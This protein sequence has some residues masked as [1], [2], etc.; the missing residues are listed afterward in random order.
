MPTR[1][2][3]RTD[4]DDVQ[5]AA[6][7]SV[8]WAGR[9]WYLATRSLVGS[10]FAADPGLVEEPTITDEISL[11]AGGDVGASFPVAFCLPAVR[12]QDLIDAGYDLEDITLELA[13]VWHRDGQLVHEWAAREVR[14]VGY[15]IE[16]VHDDPEQ[17]AGYIACTLEDSPYRTERPVVPF[18]WEITLDTFNFAP[19]FD[20][21]YPWV[22]GRPAPAGEQG[23]PPAPVVLQVISGAALVNS[24]IMVSV[25]WSV[26]SQVKVHDSEGNSEVASIVYE[27]DGL[28]QTCALVDLS[29]T[30]LDDTLGVT[31]TTAWTEGPA[32]TPYGDSD[33]LSIAAYLLAIG[34]ADI[35]IPAWISSS[36]LLDLEMGGYIDDP[37]SRAWE[38]ARN[39]LSGLPVTMRRARDGWAPVLLDPYLAK[40]VC[41]TTWDEDGPYRRVSSWAGAGAARVGQV[42]VSADVSDLRIGSTPARDAALPHS[43]VRHLDGLQEVGLQT[44]WSWTASTRY[45]LASWAARIGA[46]GWEAAAYQVPASFGRVQAGEWVQLSS[47]K[48]YAIV[49]RRSLA[50]GVWDY[51]LARPRAR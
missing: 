21:R 40:Q 50:D 45:R 47:D 37:D 4:Y 13:I 36:R 38:V 19:D 41:S 46:M 34:G 23:G 49:Q 28:G 2:K 1:S 43:W 24:K 26:A 14:A 10:K 12:V 48:T 7:L 22:L 18:S 17:P 35:D 20:V 25:G 29:T 3:G 15:A 51:T 8:T 30:S 42:E 31:Y 6:V 16:A 27:Q 44:A 5:V 39:L 32:L 9:T 11:E 33:P